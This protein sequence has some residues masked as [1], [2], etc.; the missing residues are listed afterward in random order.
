MII[1]RVTPDFAGGT[2]RFPQAPSTG[3]LS[4]TGGVAA[5]KRA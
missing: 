1:D 3:P 4:R 2:S 5:G